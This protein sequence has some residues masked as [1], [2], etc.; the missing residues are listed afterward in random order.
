MSILTWIAENGVIKKV[1]VF[2]LVRVAETVAAF[3]ASWLEQ[4]YK[5]TVK[6]RPYL[7]VNKLLRQDT[8]CQDKID[9]FYFD[10]SQY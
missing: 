7:N 9:S 3:R 1:R 8:L 4:D 10:L 6:Y 5:Y 2:S